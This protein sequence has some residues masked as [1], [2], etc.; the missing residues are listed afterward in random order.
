MSFSLLA[1]WQSGVQCGVSA[2]SKIYGRPLVDCCLSPDASAVA[3]D[4]TLHNGQAHARAFVFFGA[5]QALKHAE[6]FTN[7]LHIKAHTVV[8]DKI[9]ALP[10]VL[11][12]ANGDQR[13]FA[14]TGELE[15][16]GEQVD[17]N[18]LEQARIG[19][20]HGQI[21]DGDVDAPSIVL[22]AQ[23][24]KHLTH[25]VSAHDALQLERLATQAREGEEIID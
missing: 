15:G 23:F 22:M 4:D 24:P 18:L 21:A 8:L 16:V 6:E 7:V 25:E 3:V 1:L 19:L 14:L 17:K 5:V 20:A 10:F 12:A 2:E 9:D 13:H 11:P